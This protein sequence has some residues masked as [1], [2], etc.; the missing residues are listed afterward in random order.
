MKLIFFSW[1]S[2]LKVKVVVVLLV[3][4]YCYTIIFIKSIE[5]II[6][7]IFP[8]ISAGFAFLNPVV[9]RNIFL[10]KVFVV[11]LLLDTNGCC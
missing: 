10:I 7:K 4:N 1:C 11:E 8:D 2:I 3:D 9:G 6:R 5:Y